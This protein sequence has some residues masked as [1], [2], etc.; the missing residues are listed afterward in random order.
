[1]VHFLNNALKMVGSIRPEAA[2]WFTLRSGIFTFRDGKN[3]II[4]V[5]LVCPCTVKVETWMSF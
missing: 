3:V 2:F 4:Y 5:I 1:M